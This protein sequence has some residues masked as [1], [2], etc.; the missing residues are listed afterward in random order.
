[1]ARSRMA[2]A[3]GLIRKD[4]DT[5]GSGMNASKTPFVRNGTIFG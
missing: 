4:R 1:M 2:N 5:A 3:A